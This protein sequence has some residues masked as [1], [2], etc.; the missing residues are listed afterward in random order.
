MED[1]PIMSKLD[2]QLSAILGALNAQSDKVNAQSDKLNDLKRILY[3]KRITF[4]FMGKLFKD[5]HAVE[6]DKG[7]IN[8]KSRCNW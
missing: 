6:L 1:Y 3:L 4:E 5:G 8:S 7:D 2:E